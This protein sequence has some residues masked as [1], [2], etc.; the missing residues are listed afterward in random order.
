MLT[1]PA[2]I[3][4]AVA[5][6]I[7]SQ[8][9]MGLNF[10]LNYTHCPQQMT[11]A[12]LPLLCKAAGRALGGSTPSSSVLLA[13]G[14]GTLTGQGNSWGSLGAPRGQGSGKGASRGGEPRVQGPFLCGMSRLCP[15]PFLAWAS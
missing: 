14:L 12:W 15:S 4:F 6:D 5:A 11:N 1:H 8:A 13:P 7:I 10:T 2:I 9:L 3:I